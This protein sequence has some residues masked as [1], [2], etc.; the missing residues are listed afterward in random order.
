MR[1]TKLCTGLMVAFG[2]VLLSTGQGAYAQTEQL[3]RV[4]ITGSAIKRID[5]ETAQPV[6]VLKLDDLRKEGVTNVEQIIARISSSQSQQTT[7]QSVG[8]GTGGATFADLRGIG[9]N[10]TLVLLNGRRIANNSIDGSAP[11]LNTIP[12]A[13][14]DRIEVLRD[15]ASALY[16]TDAIGGVINFITRRSYTGLTLT[17]GFDSPQHAGGKAHNASAVGGIGDLDKDKFNVLASIDYQKQNR[18]GAIQRPF[19]ATGFLPDSGVFRSSGSTDP[20]NYSQGAGPGAN[21]A[22]PACNANPYIFHQAGA[23]CREDFS[24]FVDLIPETERISGLINGTLKF[25]DNHQ[26]NISYFAAHDKNGT[27]IAPVPFAALIMNP[28]TPFFPGNGLTPAPTNFTIN[29]ALPI[30]I[31]WRDTPNGSRAQQDINIQQRFLASLE[32]SLAGWDYNTGIAYNQ[33]KVYSDLTGGYADGNI[34]TPGVRDGVIN[35]FG[36]QTAAGQALLDSALAVGNLVFGKSQTWTVDAR[37]SRELADWFTAGRPAAIAVGAEFRREKLAFA[38]NTVYAE[39]VVSSTGTDPATDQKG[40]RNIEAVYTELNIPILKELEATV[41]VRHDRYSDFGNTTN[42]KVSFRY[43]PLQQLLFRGAYSTGFRAPSLYELNNPT[44][45]NNSAN[46]FDDPIRC[47]NGVP[48]AGVSLVDNCNT[49]FITLNGGNKTLNPERAKNFT[50]GLVFE[51]FTDTSAGID[52]WWVKI[53]HQI[54]VLPDTLIFAD[55]TRYAGLF[56]RAAD[57]SLSVDGSQCP[58]AACG[59]VSQLTSN[60]GEINTNGFDLNAAYRLRTSG[61]GNV[62]FTFN[63]TYVIKNEYQQEENGAFLQNAGTYSGTGPIFRWQHNLSADWTFGA[64]GAGVVN[65]F[66]TGYQ[67][68]N[69]PNGVADPAFYGRVGSYT[70]WDVYGSWSPIKSANIL[71]G[72]RNALD[73]NPPFSNQGRTFQTGY[74]P[75]YTDPTGRAYYVRGT[76][77]F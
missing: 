30:R 26:L 77:T 23:A 29:P 56:H 14:I 53:R 75:R 73:R 51:P 63:G 12:F 74:D 24:K 52:F 57:G 11:D 28:G 3:E 72:I 16:G 64:W 71:V 19:A 45:Y 2:G 31:R 69:D 1:K 18:I 40:S 27:Q 37:A 49:Q 4:E 5:A 35:P 15:G 42:P 10:K 60:L 39:K 76:Y 59:Y 21:P 17:A 43:Q 20:A 68:Q 48:A 62:R 9:Q 41:A 65:H 8:L 36:A 32:G 46:S 38:A 54:S 6:T 70:T 50:L 25:A 7:S 44:T 34:I 58:G 33:N 61:Y 13:A 47:P 66:K 55:P 22:G 67:D